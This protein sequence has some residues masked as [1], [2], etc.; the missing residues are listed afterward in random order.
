LQLHKQ[1]NAEYFYSLLSKD[2]DRSFLE[3][4]DVGEDFK[5]QTEANIW[6]AITA[7]VKEKY[8]FDI[9]TEGILSAAENFANRKGQWR[10]LWERFSESPKRYP[11]IPSRIRNCQIPQTGDDFDGWPQWNEDQEK[12]LQDELLSLISKA[13]DSARERILKLEDE[14]KMRRNL[15]WKELG[16]SPWRFLLHIWRFSPALHKKD[17]MAETLKI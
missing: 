15:V 3:W 14:H 7:K 17:L 1:L 5:N 16:E 10:A 13:A 6:M 12:L 8:N 11:N 2:T 9:E 4:L